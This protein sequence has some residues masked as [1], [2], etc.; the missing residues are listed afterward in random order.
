MLKTTIVEHLQIIGDNKRDDVVP[1]ALLKHQQP[2]HAAIAVLK[3]V[4]AFKA[5]MEIQNFGQSFA[6]AFIIGIQQ[7]SHLRSYLF[8]LRSTLSAHFIGEFLV[9]SHR[10][11]SFAAVTGA[12]L[13]NG[14]ELFD[15][16]LTDLSFG[17]IDDHVDAAE[18]IGRLYYVVHIHCRVSDADGIGFKNIAGLVVGQTAAFDVVGIIG[19]VNLHLVV[20]SAG[21][22]ALLFTAP[23]IP[24]VW[25]A[26]YAP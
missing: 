12:R 17:T 2:P 21:E 4:D 22:L 1:Q 20:D 11:P 16:P 8:G 3:G 18:V 24:E 14:V 15:E 26:L 25:S 19:Q 10:K 5:H 13:Q 23:D 6:G 9:I 7:L